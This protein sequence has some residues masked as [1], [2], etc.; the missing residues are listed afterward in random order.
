MIIFLSLSLAAKETW[1]V[2]ASRGD[3]HR[4]YGGQPVTGEDWGHTVALLADGEPIC[5]G[6]L[7]APKVVLSA[8]HCMG[9]GGPDAVS[10]GNDGATGQSIEVKSLHVYPD[11]NNTYDVAVLRLKHAAPVD[12]AV[13]ALPCVLDQAFADGRNVTIVGFGATDKND[14]NTR[15]NQVTTVVRD[16]DCSEINRF[17]CNSRVSPNGEF[18]AGKDG[19]DSC[20]GDSG[21]PVYVTQGG[22]PYLVGVTS[23]GAT[24]DE[25]CGEGGVYVRADAVFGWIETQSGVTLDRPACDPGSDYDSGPEAESGEPGDQDLYDTGDSGGAWDTGGSWQSKDPGFLGCSSGGREG[26]GLAFIVG[27]LLLLGRRQRA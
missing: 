11:P 25:D 13:I 17:G 14:W 7:I 21:G 12:H 26:F 16:H 23:R 22:Q 10:F 3:G 1:T 18:V 27:A 19:K 24:D 15:K 20:F 4:V 8:A 6:T 5:T 2:D 9:E